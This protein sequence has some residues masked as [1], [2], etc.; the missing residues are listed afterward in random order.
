MISG[1][2]ER[3]DR[4]FQEPLTAQENSVET[5]YQTRKWGRGT[6]VLDTC[7]ANADNISPKPNPK[8]STI[9]MHAIKTH[10]HLLHPQ[11]TSF[12]LFNF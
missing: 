7:Y 1:D 10:A 11:F 2:T 5:A 12:P 9:A 6:D 4:D 3:M 8:P